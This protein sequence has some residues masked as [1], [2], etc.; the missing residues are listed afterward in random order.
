MHA[1]SEQAISP[2]DG[3]LGSIVLVSNTIHLTLFGLS[4]PLI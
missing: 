1:I 3:K 4:T 2:R